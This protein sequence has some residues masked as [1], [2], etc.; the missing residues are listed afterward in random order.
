MQAGFDAVNEELFQASK[1]ANIYG[2]TLGP[3]L[4]NLGNLAYV[5]VALAGGT[6]LTLGAPNLGF[7]GMAL[8]IDIVVPF[9][10]LT[11]RFAGSIGQVSQQ[12]NFVVMGL[13]GAERIFA[14]MGE[15]SETDAGYV[16]LV[17]TKR[18]DNGKFVA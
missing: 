7:G 18:D 2:N 14:L 13:A 11:K 16:T 9:L 17:R 4:M 8:S 15:E 1:S 5:L 12:I 6:F 3:I 10:N